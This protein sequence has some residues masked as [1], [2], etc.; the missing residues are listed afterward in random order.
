MAMGSLLWPGEARGIQQSV[1][2]FAAQIPGDCSAGAAHRSG[3]RSR[4]EVSRAWKRA[5]HA[6]F[7]GA[8]FAIPVSAGALPRG[9]ILR[10]AASLLDLWQQGSRRTVEQDALVGRKQ[11]VAG[12]VGS[13][14][15]RE[16]T[17]CQRAGRLFRATKNVAG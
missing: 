6:L 2:G 11:A 16:T 14:N 10:A 1:V 5:V 4:R 13:F 15:R 12:G 7:S 8:H 9:W 3:F 17:G